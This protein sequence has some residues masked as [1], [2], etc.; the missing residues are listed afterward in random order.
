MKFL[1]T[2]AILLFALLITNFRNMEK[3]G[4]HTKLEAYCATLEAEF[5]QIPEVRKT[6]LRE[7]S[8]YVQAKIQAGE[9]T[10]LTVICTHN[11][12]RSH[13]GQLWLKAA[14][15]FYNIGQVETFS[16]GT[17]AT[18]FNPR[19]VAAMQKA[20][21]E[22][23]KLDETDNP[24]YEA[25]MGPTFEKLVLFS[26]KYSHTANPSSNFAAIMVCTEADAACP[27]V[28]GADGRYAI[29]YEDPKSFDGTDTETQAY[30]ERSRQIA[31]EMFFLM[32]EARG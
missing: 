22:L 18:A 4:F 24:K 15:A 9:T 32:K 30:D 31:R 8:Q 28:A 20:G 11:S 25:S 6:Q 7:I 2:T 26:K 29:P 13:M 10:Q 3:P 27:L 14:A 17:E 1:K 12:R 23:K 21:F 16:G 19:A 5:D